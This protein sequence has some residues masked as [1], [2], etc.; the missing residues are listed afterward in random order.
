MGIETILLTF[1]SF[2][3]NNPY[4]YDHSYTVYVLYQSWITCL[5]RYLQYEKIPQFQQMIHNYMLVNIDNIFDEL[6]ELNEEYPYNIYNTRCFEVDNYI[7]N[8]DMIRQSLMNYYNYI[9]YIENIA[10]ADSIGQELD[11]AQL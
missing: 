5:I 1:H 2:L 3:D 11:Y 4:T 10:E 8:Y 9:N 7:I 6:D